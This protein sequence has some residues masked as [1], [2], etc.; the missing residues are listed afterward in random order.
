MPCG[1][2]SCHEENGNKRRQRGSEPDSVKRR[3]R[4]AADE[5]GERDSSCKRRNDVHHHGRSRVSAAVKKP[6]AG[7]DESQN[8]NFKAE[9][10]HVL[11]SRRDNVLIS[12]KDGKRRFGEVS[13]PD[14]KPD[15][16]Q[17]RVEN[18]QLEK[19]QGAV[20]LLRPDVLRCNGR[21]RHTHRHG[22]Q[23]NNPVQTSADPVAGRGVKPE[24]VHDSEN[25]HERQVD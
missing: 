3:A 5:P 8:Q 24:S 21:H 23:K 4:H 6:V 2:V 12:R 18:T 22:R 11:R 19:L 15:A 25:N 20:E 10:T 16:N 13:H 1:D 7:K 17:G 14:E 9:R